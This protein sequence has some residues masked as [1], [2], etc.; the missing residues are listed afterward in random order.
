M[1]LFFYSIM[2]A[3]LGFVIKQ[4]VNWLNVNQYMMK[5]NN[6][7]LESIGAI[8]VLWSFSHLPV[9]E[10]SIFS[11]IVVLLVG[12]SIIDYHTFQIPLIFVIIGIIGTIFGVV[13]DV[14]YFSA[15]LLGVFIGAVIPMMIVALLWS[16]TKRQG[17]GFGDIQLGIVLGAWLGPMRMA[18]TLFFA[19]FMS[20][21]VWMGVSLVKGFD[22]DRALPFGP[23][24]SIAGIGTYIGSFYYPEFFHLLMI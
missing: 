1:E 3:A 6:V 9:I 21:L 20:L 2:G 18:I 19:A 23:F 24:L 14:I 5:N 13:F 12:I 10:A 8:S 4:L 15:A 22:K 7:I 11:M 17:M 16:I